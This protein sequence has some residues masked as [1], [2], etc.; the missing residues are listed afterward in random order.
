MRRAALLLVLPLLLVSCLSFAEED[1]A[2]P[3]AL[4]SPVTPARPAGER[5]ALEEVERWLYLIDVNLH[6]ETAEQVR[7]STYDMVVI[8]FITSEAEN[9]DYPLVEVIAGW[10][11]APHPKLVLAY[12]DI[13]E[14]ESYRTYWQEEWRVGDP[15][16]I[17]GEDPDG[18]AENYPVAFWHDAWQEIWLDEGGYLEQIVAAGF[19]GIYLDWVEAYDDENVLEIAVEEGVDTRQ[20]MIWWVT[21]LAE[22]GRELRPGFLVVAQNGAELTESEAYVEVIDALAQEQV[23]F[24]GG[25]DNRPPGDCPL[26]RTEEE[27]ETDAY[28]RSLSPPCR[29]QHDR[30]PEST[31]HVSSEAYLVLLH[32]AQARGLTIFTVDYA[33]EPENVTWVY[34]T[35]RSLGFVPFVSSRALDRYL[36]PVP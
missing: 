21:D 26:P 17:A 18:W 31:L 5:P 24:D 1:E 22:R 8:D 25:A 3:R 28:R 9:E 2:L 20:E 33:L 12:V 30:Y 34:E 14:A 19:D 27:V 15:V 35:S 32:Q 13:G 6:A 36:P 11:T 10:Q 16:W 23:W 7:A 4:P 29:R